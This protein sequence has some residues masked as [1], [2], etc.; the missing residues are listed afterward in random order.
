MKKSVLIIS[1]HA[2]GG[3]TDA[4]A[5]IDVALSYA[6]FEQDV[7]VLFCGDGAWQLLRDQQGMAHQNKQIDKLLQS[8]EMY[9]LTKLFVE[10]QALTKRGINLD[11][12]CVKVTPVDANEITAMIS[13]HTQVL[14]F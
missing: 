14:N 13:Q 3:T 5:C 9:G 11:N 7:A 12:C 4:L 6:A 10:E 8:Y 2:P 1:S